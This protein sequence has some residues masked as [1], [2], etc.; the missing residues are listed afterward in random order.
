MI[1]WPFS[2]LTCAFPR[3]MVSAIAVAGLLLAVTLLWPPVAQAATTADRFRAASARLVEAAEAASA[4]GRTDDARLRYEQ[5]LVA[6]PRSV[7]AL[8]GLGRLNATAGQGEAALRLF[9]RALALNPVNV[10]VLAAKVEAQMTLRDLDGAH[11]T[12][13]RLDTLCA[14]L[15]DNCGRLAPMRRALDAARAATASGGG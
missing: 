10:T 4:A 7:S 15:D 2:S 11:A 12:L 1:A 5:A 13:D 8:V 9:D 3:P 14:R 6:D